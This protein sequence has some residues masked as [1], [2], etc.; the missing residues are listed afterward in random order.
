MHG[1]M[2]RRRISGTRA[3]APARPSTSD[4][5]TGSSGR[6]LLM[7]RIGPL[8]ISL[9]SARHRLGLLQAQREVG[10]R[11]LVGLR[12][13][14]RGGGRARDADRGAAGT[15]GGRRSAVAARWVLRSEGV[16]PAATG[17]RSLVRLSPAR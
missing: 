1:G 11:Q 12:R 13:R 7:G 3:R 15:T 17:S 10:E 8:C 14:G 5:W 6:D 2:Q 16:L 4:G 9:M